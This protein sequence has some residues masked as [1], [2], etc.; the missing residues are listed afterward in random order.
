MMRVLSVVVL[1]L[2]SVH[3]HSVGESGAATQSARV[4]VDADGF[5]PGKLEVKRGE[6]VTITFVRVTDATC[7]KEVVFPSLKIRRALP[8]NKPVEVRFTPQANGDVTFACGMDMLRGTVT[9]N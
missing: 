5:K 2:G 7:A 9:V 4:V 1:L 8:L 3:G 6:A